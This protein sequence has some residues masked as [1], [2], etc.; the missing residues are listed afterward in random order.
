MKKSLIALA[1]LGFAGGAMAQSSVTLYGVANVGFG[2]Q[3]GSGFK[4]MDAPNGT[5]SRWGLR[6]TEDLG[7]GMKINFLLESG[8]LMPTGEND[9]A[10]NRLFQR[11]SWLG[12]SGGFGEVRMGRQYTVGFDASIWSMPATRTNAQLLAGFGFNGT[13]A[14]NDGMI[15]Y[16]SPNFSG[17]KF[18]ASYQLTKNATIPVGAAT[19][20]RPLEAALMYANGPL[21]ANLSFVKSKGLSTGF[22]LNAGYNFGGIALHGG[23]VKAPGNTNRGFWVGVKGSF[24]AFTPWAQVARNTKGANKRTGYELGVNYAMSKR[25]VLY[26]VYGHRSKALPV[27]AGVAAPKTLYGLGIQHS[28]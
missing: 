2:G 18:E 5:G 10:T 25:T 27:T 11:S 4:M 12:V 1:V 20:I 19:Q 14:R 24:G 23:Y 6:G 8:Y 15:K 21:N 17:F 3:T 13:P 9:T 28:F 26:A 7:G 16:L 22:G